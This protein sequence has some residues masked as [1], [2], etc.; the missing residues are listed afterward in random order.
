MTER[1]ATLLRDG[2][3]TV[4]PPPPPAAEILRQGK[5]RR[6]R[7]RTTTALA[8]VIVVAVVGAG[9]VAVVGRGSGSGLDPAK[10]AEFEQWG[11]VAVGRDVHIGRTHV[12]AEGDISA[13]Y[14]SADGVVI[15]TGGR[16][17]LVRPDGEVSSIDVD[18]PDRVP[19]FEPDSTRFAYAEAVGA[20]RW[21]VVVH[22]TVTD[23]ELARV[24]VA[25][26][27]YGGWEAP[28]VAI[29]G[30]LVWIHLADHWAEVD[31]RTG[32]VRDVP[33][34][35]A[36]YEAANGAYAVQA[37]GYTERRD[38]PWE[39]R[40]WADGSL[41]GTADLRP[42]WYA[43]FSPDGRY[44]RAFPN[45][46]IPRVWRPEVFDPATGLSRSV[47]T[48]DFGWTPAGDLLIVEGDEIRVCTAM[49]DECRTRSFDR[50]AGALRIGGN[51]YES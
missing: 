47:P 8:A 19:G 24:D 51:P 12:R 44:L 11:A 4:P 6:R 10:R 21:E 29:D 2:A 38:E 16:Y 35:G 49:T 28:P 50:G 30:D 43:F 22:D 31:W 13:M 25:G 45:E 37:G 7:S 15:R 27:A 33:G 32:E 20:D 48:E 9:V 39:I 36:T 40:S 1:L 42:G 23:E 46:T 26:P 17:Q 41:I 3:G 14:Y 34:T 18:I 5:R